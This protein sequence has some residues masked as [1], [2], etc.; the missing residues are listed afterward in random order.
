M[1]STFREKPSGWSACVDE[2]LSANLREFELEFTANIGRSISR[3]RHIRGL[4]CRHLF[5]EIEKAIHLI[6]NG[7]EFLRIVLSL[8]HGLQLPPTFWFVKQRFGHQ[9]PVYKNLHF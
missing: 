1:T 5:V 8:S 7:G 9:S 6:D 2:A 3:F 4:H